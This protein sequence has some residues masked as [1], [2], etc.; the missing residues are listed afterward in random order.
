MY[1]FQL[2]ITREKASYRKKKEVLNCGDFNFRYQ[3]LKFV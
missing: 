2:Y 3:F 1:N